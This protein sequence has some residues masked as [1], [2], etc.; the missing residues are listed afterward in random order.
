MDI[1]THGVLGASLA[2]S[3]APRDEARLAAGVG[4]FS[5]LLADSDILIRSAEDPLLEL[6]FHRHFT[7]ALVFVPVIALVAAAALW[8]LLRRRIAFARLYLYALLGGALSG[9]LDACTSYGTHLLWPFSGERIAWSIVSIVDPVFTLLLVVPLAVGML[10][11]QAL[12]ARVGVVLAAG[13]LALGALQQERAEAAAL[14]LAEQRGHRAERLLVKPTFGNLVLWRSIYL[15]DGR[16]HAD[17][18]RVFL[19]GA[20]RVY[21]GA[22]APLFA[23]ERDLPWAPPGSRAR[24]DTERFI[25]FSDGYVVQHPGRPE[26]VGD[27]RYAML[28]TRLEPLW[29][30]EYDGTRADRAP[31]FVTD[32]SLDRETR[33]RFAAMLLGRDV[34][35]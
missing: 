24:A 32:R 17:G 3:A 33:R 7:H 6:E 9:V 11:R 14:A 23:P 16:I 8:P 26:F 15:A 31:R 10:K 21:A 35:G 5:G 28:P 13:Y 2:Q 29:G 25:T 30:I 22:S 19:P 20:T 1:L 27:A 34:E 12:A 18:I 4:L